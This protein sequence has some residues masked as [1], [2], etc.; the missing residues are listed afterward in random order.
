MEPTAVKS[1]LARASNGVVSPLYFDRQIVRAEDLTLDRASHD[2]ELAR[3]RRLLHG[4]GVVAGLIPTVAGTS[5]RVSA[6]YGI[7]RTGDEVF[8]PE[9][10]EV[11]DIVGRVWGC[12]GT[13]ELTCEVI[14]LAERERLARERELTQITSWLIAR[15]TQSESDPRPGI[16][17]GCEHP[18]NRLMPTRAC[19]VVSIELLCALP[20][21]LAA[22]RPDC[23]ALMPYFCAAPPAMVPLPPIAPPDQNLLILGRIVAQLET[24]TFQ[25]IDRRAVMPVALLQSWLQ[26]CVCPLFKVA[27]PDDPGPEPP[28]D[29]EPEGPPRDG[30]GPRVPIDPEIP[31]PREPIGP[32]GPRVDPGVLGWNEFED[33]LAGNGFAPAAPIP[34]HPRARGRAPSPDPPGPRSWP[35]PRRCG[36]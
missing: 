11:P 32:I 10:V 16:A 1:A 31:I 13:D 24:A 27:P 15:P 7:T 5:L 14:D 36:C 29:P 6:G 35:G 19:D 26:S 25:P 23:A 12:C 17:E 4:W 2:R 34:T 9:A 8:L 30:P 33:V 21:D 28:R 18:A 22:P 3:M 20:P